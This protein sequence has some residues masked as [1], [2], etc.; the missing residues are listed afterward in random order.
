MNTTP[1]QFELPAQTVKVY[2]N[3]RVADLPMHAVVPIHNERGLTQAQPDVELLIPYGEGGTVKARIKGK[4][5]RK[6]VN[7]IDQYTNPAQKLI[8]FGRL[9]ASGE[10]EA[11]GF[12]PF[13]KDTACANRNL[14]A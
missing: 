5:F 3:I 12:A 11:A 8:L 2:I 10:I 4:T 6:I 13:A 14:V 1:V 9:N 7:S